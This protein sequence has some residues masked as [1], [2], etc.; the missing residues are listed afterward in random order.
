MPRALSSSLALLLSTA[1]CGGIV[2]ES[3][4]RG[5]DQ[6]EGESAADT[7]EESGDTA[8]DGDG[9]TSGEGDGD[10]SGDGDGDDGSCPPG[11]LG[12]ACD[13][14]ECEAGLE[15]LEGICETDPTPYGNCGW[16]AEDGW[17]SC[18]GMGESPDPDYPIDCGNIGLTDDAVCPEELSVIGCC[19]KFAN[20]WYCDEEGFAQRKPCGG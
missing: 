20:L 18:E 4:S 15:C 6:G 16:S 12:C 5:S 13:N 14:D 7:G 1:G 3:S 8:G 11:T 9:D 2:I 10:S 19:D 17:Y